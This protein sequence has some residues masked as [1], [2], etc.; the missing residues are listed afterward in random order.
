[1]RASGLGQRSGRAHQRRPGG[2]DHAH[3]RSSPTTHPAHKVERAVDLDS[4]AL[5]A[6]TLHGAHIGDSTSLNDTVITA[7]NQLAAA[8]DAAL[9]EFVAD[10]G[11]HSNQT[12][13]DLRAIG[14][15]S[16]ISEPQRG[17]RQWTRAP[18]AQRAVYG[19]HRR[20]SGG[21]G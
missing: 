21:R 11:Y 13:S 12:L 6:V 18:E 20:V 14:V 1:M 15:R 17:R 4:G 16:Y 7:V 19:N 10:K 3:K 9:T 5:V 8:A 2:H